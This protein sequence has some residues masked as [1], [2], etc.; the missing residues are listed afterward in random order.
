MEDD[1]TPLHIAAFFGHFELLEVLLE[2]FVELIDQ[3]NRYGWSP[4]MQACHQGHF[5]CVKLLLE[6]G[7][8]PNITNPLGITAL[9]VATRGG[10]EKVI[11]LLL[12]DSTIYIPRGKNNN[13]FKG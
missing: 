6:N 12:N 9:T 3:L 1:N 13:I 4:L 7:A 5:D 11:E 8:D 2:E 10:F